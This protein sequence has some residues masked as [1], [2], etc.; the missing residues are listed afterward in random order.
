MLILDLLPWQSQCWIQCSYWTTYHDRVSAGYNTHLGPFSMTESVLDAMPIFTIYHNR[1]SLLYA[2][3]ILDLLPWQRIITIYSVHIGH[4][5]MTENHYYIQCPYW[6]FNNV[7]KSLLDTMSI[8]DLLPWKGITRV[9][10]LDLLPCQRVIQ[11]IVSILDL[12]PC[13]KII[14]RYSVY[15]GPFTMPENHY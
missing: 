10:I 8:L 7:R 6:T 1:E 2:V 3:S 15:I 13:Q 5:T 4:F 9:F 14:T 11:D 12:L